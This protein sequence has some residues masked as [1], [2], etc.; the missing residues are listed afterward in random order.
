M[1]RCKMYHTLVLSIFDMELDLIEYLSQVRV[2]LGFFA[3]PVAS[4]SVDE[5]LL[6]MDYFL[7]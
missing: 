6:R 5:K 3:L 2:G 1:L 4:R 7:A